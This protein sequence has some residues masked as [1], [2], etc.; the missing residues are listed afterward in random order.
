MFTARDEDGRSC[1]AED[2][3]A[4]AVFRP[5]GGLQFHGAVAD[6]GSVR[7]ERRDYDPIGTTSSMLPPARC[8][9]RELRVVE[10]HRLSRS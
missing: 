1:I 5:S 8:A 9:D 2:G 10:V 3:E 6:G 7:V 4:S